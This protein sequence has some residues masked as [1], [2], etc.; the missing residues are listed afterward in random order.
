MNNMTRF[1]IVC[2]VGC[3]A[4]PAAGQLNIPWYSIDGG[5]TMSSTGGQFDLGG[6]VGQSDCGPT[7]ISGSFTLDGGFWS[8]TLPGPDP[9]C[10]GEERV[11]KASC[12][13]RN[14][15][16]QLKV[17]LVGGRPGDTFTVMLSSDGASR[18]GTIN[19]RGKGKAKF[20]NRPPSDSGAASVE[21]ACGA[22]SQ[23]EYTCP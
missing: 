22:A 1:L 13:D 23:K 3:I 19:N 18:S 12:K 4:M 21:W 17:I 10:T 15:E 6:T 16:N 11:K 2:W 9:G 20:N 7:L 8:A 14:G 5:G